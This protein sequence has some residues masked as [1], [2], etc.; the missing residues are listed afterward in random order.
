MNRSVKKLI[1]ISVFVLCLIIPSDNKAF[2]L[3]LENKITLNDKYILVNYGGSQEVYNKNNEKYIYPG[4]YRNDTTLN[5]IWIFN[6][7]L[8]NGRLELSKNLKYLTALN[9]YPNVGHDIDLLDQYAIKFYKNGELIKLYK[10]ADFI[11]LS[12]VKEIPIFSF[13]WQCR[14]VFKGNYLWIR[15]VSQKDFYFDIRTGEM[16]TK[17]EYDNNLQ[18]LYIVIILMIELSV[19]FLALVLFEKKRN[20]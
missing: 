1:I 10:I 11:E 13:I 4:L 7:S 2:N 16:V 19:F 15:M 8:K 6:G 20:K 3:G 14:D 12:D 5:P 17:R 18:P 9:G